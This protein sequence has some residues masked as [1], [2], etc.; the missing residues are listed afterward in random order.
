MTS[1]LAALVLLA[2]LPVTPSATIETQPPAHTVD[3]PGILLL[4]HGGAESWNENVREIARAVDAT[5][6]TEIAFGMATRANIQA[7]ADRLAARGAAEIVAVPLFVSSH[8]SVVRAT[9]YLL[10]LRDDAPPQL[11]AFAKMSHGSSSQGGHT[12]T[13]SAHEG[14]NAHAGHG[15]HGAAAAD[16]GTKPI[17]TT[18]PVR[19]TPAL[20]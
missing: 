8:S 16:D 5:H 11:A 6:P 12:M 18:L 13:A 3:R 17:A 7:A 14:D 15:S 2:T 20:N 1:I 4:A 10:G 19:I 9:E